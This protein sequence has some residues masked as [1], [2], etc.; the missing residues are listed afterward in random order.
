MHPPDP[1]PLKIPKR[2][3]GTGNLYLTTL[4]F[5]AVVLLT[6]AAGHQMCPQCSARNSA[7]AK[8]LSKI[9]RSKMTVKTNEV[10]HH[11][12]GSIPFST[13]NMILSL[14]FLCATYLFLL[15]LR[16][17]IEVSVVSA[18]LFILGIQIAQFSPTAHL[19]SEI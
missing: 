6:A 7:A 10:Q 1:T 18:V 4:S 11:L 8:K 16:S 9:F 2:E 15:K 3:P 13:K 5:M 17:F 12:Y 14:C 19:S